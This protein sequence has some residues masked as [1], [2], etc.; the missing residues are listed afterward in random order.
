M[1]T[2]EEENSLKYWNDFFKNF[3]REDIQVDDWLADF[4]EVIEK[5]Q[6]PILD[7]GSGRGND[8]LYLIN[9]GKKVI[10]SDQSINSINNIKRNIPE[11]YDTKCFNFLDGIP[12]DDQSFDI[13][14][15]D[16]CLHYFREQDTIKLIK[17][18][19]RV[20][21]NNGHLMIRLNSIND[22]NFGAGQGIEVEHHLYQTDDCRLKRFFD[23]EDIKYFFKDFELEY[24]NEE[25]MTRYNLEKR[26]YKCLVKK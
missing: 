24:V 25:I 1:R 2:V 8:T 10:A 9:K 18:I 4:D 14:V 11:V 23:E 26:L 17:D 20:L 6:T 15:G 5:C 21:T 3:T 12:F 19:R 7:L 13:I 22:T 16:L